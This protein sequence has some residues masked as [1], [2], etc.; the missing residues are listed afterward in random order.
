MKVPELLSPVGDLECLKAAVQNGA[1]TVYLGAS[2]FNARARATN[3]NNE[4]LKEAIL[5][6]KLR[7]VKV[8]LTLNTL[9]KENELNEAISLAVFAYNCGVDA[10]IIQDLGLAKFLHTNYPEITLHASTQMTVHN[11]E[12]VK[13]LEAF[14]FKRVVLSRELSISEIEYIRKNTNVEL[15]VFIHGA[16]CISYS[17]QCLFSSMVGNRSGNR[18]MCAQPCRLPCE[19]YS[20]KNLLDK[21]F[22][23]SP[24]DQSAID[25]LPAL[26]KSGIDCFKIEGR[27]KA[28]EYV[29]TVTKI[30]RKYI[31]F[32]INNINLSDE[33][34]IN[35]IHIMIEIPNEI[36]GLSDKEELLQVFN[37][38]NF[39]KG[40]FENEPNTKLIYSKKPNNM[41]LYL[42]KIQNFNNQKGHITLKL[43]NS[44]SVG[45][46]ISINNENYTVSELM[47]KNK[48]Y[49]T[50]DSGNTV[51]LGR[52]KGNISNGMSVFR[53]EN[54]KL[55]TF[56]QSIFSSEKEL[57]NIPF[58]AEITIKKELPIKL[59][60]Y[61]KTGFYKNLKVTIDSNIIPETAENQPVSKEK[62][63]AQLSKTGNTP[64]CFEN[65]NIDLENNL[66]I[67]KIS[68][69]N[70]L[71][72]NAFAELE[73]KVKEIYTFNINDSKNV[74]E[75]DITNNIIGSSDENK[76]NKDYN[77]NNTNDNVTALSPIS[78][79]SISL[80]LNILNNNF[81]YAEL[82]GIDALYIPYKYFLNSSYDFTL[83]TLCNKFKVFLYMP[84]I[85]RENYFGALNST[86]EKSL[87]FGV[88]GFVISHISQIESLRKYNLPV[89]GNYTLNVYNN[90]S[91]KTLKDFGL[92][93]FTP[94]VELEKADLLEL[95]NLASLP[96]E[97]IVYGKT[98]LMTNNYCYLGK[99]NRCYKD[100]KKLCLENSKFYLKDRLGFEFRIVPDNTCTITTIYNSK[101]TSINYTD[102]INKINS[103]RID[104]LDEN[105]DD[106]QKIINKVKKNE[107]FE[108][109]D[110]TN[111]KIK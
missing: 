34:L 49:P 17:G 60:V 101:I 13:Q 66:F 46:R 108:G 14:G 98:P 35:Q 21:G 38:G 43:E 9:L 36:T 27:Q 86:I 55:S 45:D 58:D 91:I 78:S 77:N 109:K 57:L 88:K 68:S 12:G 85:M 87:N 61:G 22:L 48:N 41:G 80:L 54:K 2:S 7:N 8:N 28:P 75:N 95:L 84:S 33:E 15:E 47:I 79:P 56:A 73:N 63:I 81:N 16:L 92:V 107:R 1:N 32:I 50:L 37:R 64:F 44:I 93:K 23:L 26:I 51:T 74:S 100:C 70:E 53:I 76:N 67:P 94:S 18:G 89:I 59:T 82:T 24:R 4:N 31:D 83:E 6:A 72:R 5:Y 52:M 39:S 71:R 69:L 29:A 110:F 105:L 10:I 62:I 97:L 111:G 40:H 96:S 106:I 25:F 104:I 90:E 20:N 30:Y 19:L 3:F 11:L 99:S 65:I 102:F 42:G 103:V